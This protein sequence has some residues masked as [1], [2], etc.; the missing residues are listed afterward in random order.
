[1]SLSDAD[2]LE[3]LRTAR[4][5]IATA[6]AGGQLTLSYTVR[7]RTHDVANPVQALEQIETSIA[8]YER[9]V[10]RQS[11]PRLRPVSLS[12]PLGRG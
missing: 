12:R 4:D 9:K 8:L 10:N 7:G 6:I 2:H 1:M 11:R 3:A 5:A